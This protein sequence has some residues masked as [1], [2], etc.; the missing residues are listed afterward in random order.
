M[1]LSSRDRFGGTRAG[2]FCGGVVVGPTTVM[3]AA[4]CLSQDVLG[5]PP[6]RGRA[7]C[8]SSPAATEL[9]SARRARRSRCAKAWVNPAYDPTTNA[10]DFAVLT[11][12]EPLPRALRHPHGAGRRPGV[13]AGHAGRGL[14]LGRHHGRRR[15]CAG[16]AGRAGDGAAGRDVREA[17]PGSADGRTGPA[18]MVCAGEPDGGRDACQGDSGGPLVAQGRLIGPGVLGE[19]LRAGRAAPASTRGSRRWSSRALAT[20]SRPE[21]PVGASAALAGGVSGSRHES[22]RPPLGAG[23][24]ARRPAWPVAGS[25]WMRGVSARL[26]RRSPERPSAA[27]SRPV[28]PRRSS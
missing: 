28:F 19:R 26:R 25:S 1:A 7:I 3:T 2:Q 23:A 8:G 17:Y 10:G 14:R 11:L 27:P 16:A 15:L 4:H 21:A 22:G 12:A 9:Q 13:R 24:A 20:G 5:E 18:P 6:E